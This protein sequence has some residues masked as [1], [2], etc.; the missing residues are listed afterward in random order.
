V[1]QILVLNVRAVVHVW[2]TVVLVYRINWFYQPTWLS[3]VPAK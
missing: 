1:T 3:H 2:L